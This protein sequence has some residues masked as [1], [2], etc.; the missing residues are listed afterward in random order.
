MARTPLL[1]ALQ[2]SLRLARRS[3]G[4]GSEPSEIAARDAEKVRSRRDFLAAGAAAALSVSFSRC[5][6]LPPASRRGERVVIVG[7]GIAG[8]TC[9]YRLHQAGVPVRVLEAQNRVGG[10]ISSLRGHFPD[11][12]VAELGGELIDTGHEHVRR[13]SRRSSAS[14]LDDFATG[15][16]RRA[17][18]SGS[19]TA[20]GTRTPRWSRPSGPSP[21]RSTRPGETRRP[22]RRVTY[23]EPNG[24][25]A[26]DRMSI[27][28]WLDE[29]GA[30]R[31]VP[32]AA[33]R[34]L[35]PPST[36]WRSTSSRPSTS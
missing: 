32:R 16:P 25:E 19:S 20:A 27:A 13:R 15:R 29:A 12:Q 22:E 36:A 17:P 2:R 1:S 24:G 10:R 21:R 18:T 28:A 11:G 35:T 34:R 26:I 7:A 4:S 31:L 3:L 5:A 23:D 6:S 30:E 33:R 14:P 9:A 8:L